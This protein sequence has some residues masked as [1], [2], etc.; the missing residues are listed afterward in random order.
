M[1]GGRGPCWYLVSIA[2]M[3]VDQMGPTTYA[4]KYF[5]NFLKALE[6]EGGLLQPDGEHAIGA[7]KRRRQQQQVWINAFHGRRRSVL[8]Q[9]TAW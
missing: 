9:R 3:F 4:V 7:L 6:Y 8:M 1:N 2:A 5:N